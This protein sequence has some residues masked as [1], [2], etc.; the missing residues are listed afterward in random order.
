MTFEFTDIASQIRTRCQRAKRGTRRALAVLLPVLAL[1]ILPSVA[2]AQKIVKVAVSPA[3]TSPF[4]V[5]IDGFCKSLEEKAGQRYKCQTFY[6]GAIGGDREILEGLQLGTIEMTFTSTGATTNFV[7]EIRI[8]DLP[9]LFRD[10]AH[11]RA[12]LDGPIGQSYLEKF[13]ARGMVGMAWGD[14]GFRHLTNS[15]RPVTTPADA[16]GLKIRTQENPLHIQAFRAFGLNPTPMAFPE[17]YGALQQGTVDG[18][19]NPIS[20]IITSK[21]YQVQK[22]LSLT[23]HAYAPGILVISQKFFDSLP[24]ADKTLFME[25]A[26][27]GIVANR[28]QVDLDEKNGITYLKSQGVTVVE[29]V[30]RAAFE[31]ALAPSYPAFETQFGREN[32]QRIKDVR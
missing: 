20:L 5:A 16:K 29:N 6:S 24:A 30:D 3:K 1:G 25:A 22:H 28:A 4:G 31:K 14:N 23:G 9:F 8:F 15:K 26:K 11:A 27:D 7:P 32:I 18:Q 12:V 10:Y 17:L 21:F 19:E 2:S 13:R